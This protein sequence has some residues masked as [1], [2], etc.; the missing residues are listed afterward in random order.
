MKS[1]WLVA[2]L[3]AF[4]YSVLG[5]ASPAVAD[6]TD[7]VNDV[8][9]LLVERGVIEQEEATRIIERNRAAKKKRS[10]F[11]RI[12]FFGDMRGQY[13]NFW[14]D[15]DPL[16]VEKRDRSRMRYRFRLG[17]ST[18]INEHLDVAFQLTT[19]ATGRSPNETLGAGGT[20]F[21]PDAINLRQAYLTYHPFL[22]GSIP[23]GGR[24]FDVMVGKMPNLF[25]SKVGRD[26]LMWDSDITPEGIAW[27]YQ[28]NPAEDVALTFSTAYFVVGDNASASNP[29]VIPT[30]IGVKAGLS[31]NVTVGGRLSYYAWRKLDDDFHNED[32]TFL[33]AAAARSRST[34]YGNV[35]GGL[36]DGRGI[37]IGE[38][39]GWVQ[40]R[41]I[42]NWPILAY[43]SFSKNFS[44]E[45]VSRFNAGREDLAWS[46]G[47]E[48]G[49]KK[50]LATLGA[51]YF[52]LEANAAPAQMVDGFIFDG[53]TNAKGWA[54]YGVKEVYSHTDLK[55]TLYLGDPL[56][57]DIL[58]GP[59]VANSDRVRMQ[60]DI[61]VK[62]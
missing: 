46:L 33:T 38:L 15:K 1:N 20:D 45:S 21:A 14:Y 12:T 29:A 48:V 57:D 9:L 42:E 62:F 43:A 25:F 56:N 49:D 58:W 22:E 6:E 16:G 52:W 34:S 31:E 18:E 47:F 53:T 59:S 41:G 28:F 50:R 19:G 39:R 36:T 5:A 24:K 2:G 51:G 61:V 27:T 60:T 44:A 23:L 11:D 8:V 10:W 7:A 32:E 54:I 17:A 37:N 30:Q 3:A 55:V 35:P 40:Y 13:E 26:Y 4:A